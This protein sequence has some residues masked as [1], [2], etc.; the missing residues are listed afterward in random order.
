ML[1]IAVYVVNMHGLRTVRDATDNATPLIAPPY[2]NT[3]FAISSLNTAF[4]LA[5][6]RY[7]VPVVSAFRCYLTA[8]LDLLFR[9]ATTMLGAVTPR[10]RS[11]DLIALH[12]DAASH[13]FR[14]LCLYIFP[15]VLLAI[16]AVFIARQYRAA[17][18]YTGPPMAL[19]HGIHRVFVDTESTGDCSSV[20][21]L[22]I[23]LQDGVLVNWNAAR[24]SAASFVGIIARKFEFV[25]M[26]TM[27]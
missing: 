10:W 17:T 21:Q 1:I 3:R 22:I 24:H 19:S 16:G 2:L 18:T 15:Q 27:E 13:A 4:T 6:V 8:A 20:A 5:L 26:Y 9:R 12:A 14:S 23:R 11:D 7:A 25:N